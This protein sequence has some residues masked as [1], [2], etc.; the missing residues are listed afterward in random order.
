MLDCNPIGGED[1]IPG[2]LGAPLYKTLAGLRLLF[3]ETEET[4]PGRE[5]PRA[6][7]PYRIPFLLWTLV[8]Q[9][10]QTGSNPE[11]IRTLGP[12]W[13]RAEAS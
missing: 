12:S 13:V 6:R 11:M 8:R 7:E 9:R 10:V 2:L 1:S 5:R 4:P 3:H